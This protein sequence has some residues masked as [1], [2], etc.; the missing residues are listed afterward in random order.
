MSGR[1]ADSLLHAIKEAVLTMVKE[2]Q[3]PIVITINSKTEVGAT[4]TRS[5]MDPKH[6]HPSL[7]L[8][9]KEFRAM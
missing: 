8:S 6:H 1:A 3:I 7:P 9:S 4:Q 2:L 5:A